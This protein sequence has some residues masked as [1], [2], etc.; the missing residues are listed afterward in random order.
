MLYGIRL[1]NLTQAIEMKTFMSNLFKLETNNGLFYDL[2]KN[3]RFGN[4]SSNIGVLFM[5]FDGLQI[6]MTK[7]KT[8]IS[9]IRV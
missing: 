7:E 6:K 3:Y 2:R 8:L 5:Y 1:H 9:K 4:V